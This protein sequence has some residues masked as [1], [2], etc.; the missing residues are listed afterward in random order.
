M[1]DI[2]KIIKEFE[3]LPY[4]SYMQK[5]P[6]NQPTDSYFYILRH[7]AKFMM[8]SDTFHSHI[9]P[10]RTGMTGTQHIID[11]HICDLDKSKSKGIIK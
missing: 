4:K 6:K 3:K 5:R 9:E 11:A 8:R 2:S 7:L 10:V 1:K